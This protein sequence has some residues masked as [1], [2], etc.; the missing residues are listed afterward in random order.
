MGADLVISS[1]TSPALVIFR[2]LR[3][4]V[5]GLEESNADGADSG[6]RDFLTR[7]M[8]TISVGN[9]FRKRIRGLPKTFAAHLGV[10]FPRTP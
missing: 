5:G 7:R 2:F 9:R 1:G 8:S 4:L 6:A 3:S 10:S